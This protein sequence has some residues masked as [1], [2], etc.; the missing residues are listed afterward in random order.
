M[1][2]DRDLPR[3]P[4]STVTPQAGGMRTSL[5]CMALVA[6]LALTGC[7]S[8]DAPASNPTSASGDV[9]PDLAPDLAPDQEPV[10]DPAEAIDLDLLDPSL[11][12]EGFPDDVPVADG[13]LVLA[14]PTDDGFSLLVKVTGYAPEQT[15]GVHAGAVALLTGAGWTAGDATPGLTTTVLTKD[16]E[17]VTVSAFPESDGA[18]LNYLIGRSLS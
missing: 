2:L 16:G 18:G 3:W 10:A 14:D 6:A 13:E 7:G 17:Q 4:G 11:L 9:E 5:C 1:G 12:P 15:S 8:D